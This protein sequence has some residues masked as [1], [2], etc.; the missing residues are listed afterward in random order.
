MRAVAEP[1][2]VW[3]LQ[4]IMRWRGALHY[5]RIIDQSGQGSFSALQQ[6]SQASVS[7]F[8]STVQAQAAVLTFSDAFLVIAG[9]AVALVVVLLVLPERT[10]PPRIIAQQ[11]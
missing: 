1:F 10:Y 2:G 3:M 8:R 7:A 9:V 11:H 6:H 5:N 4:L